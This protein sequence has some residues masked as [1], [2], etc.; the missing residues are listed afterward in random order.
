[1]SSLQTEKIIKYVLVVL[2]V[3]IILVG[4]YFAFRYKIIDFFKQFSSNSTLG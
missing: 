3:V 1:M 4:A 2:L